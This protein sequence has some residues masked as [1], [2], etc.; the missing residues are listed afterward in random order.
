MSIELEIEKMTLEE[1]LRAMEALWANLSRNEQDLQSPAW[2][3][4]VLDEREQRVKSGQEQFV[5]WEDAKRELRD[6]LA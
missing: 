3:E 1:K 2:H 5:S 4:Q 6:R